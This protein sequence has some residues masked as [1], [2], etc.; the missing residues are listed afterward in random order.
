MFFFN[1]LTPVLLEKRAKTQAMS[2][3]SVKA[4]VRILYTAMPFYIFR[5]VPTCLAHGPVPG[6]CLTVAGTVTFS[7]MPQSGNFCLKTGTFRRSY[8]QQ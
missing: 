6:G 5:F 1:L 2:Y 7:Q 8:D 3:L 4:G